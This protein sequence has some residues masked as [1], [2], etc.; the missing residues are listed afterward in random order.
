[1]LIN[2]QA[3]D[4]FLAQ[5]V[6]V[7]LVI[8]G[9]K[10]F[11]FIARASRGS[12]VFKVFLNVTVNLVFAILVRGTGGDM[13]LGEGIT[14]LFLSVVMGSLITAGL[15]RLKKAFER[16]SPSNHHWEAKHGPSMPSK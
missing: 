5:S 3:W 8:E 6:M 12:I 2:I 11:P 1:M 9:L 16:R 15:H 13:F 14:P 10:I 4:N 7:F